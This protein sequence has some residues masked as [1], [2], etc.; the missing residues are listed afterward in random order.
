VNENQA[1]TL[2]ME[3]KNLITMPY[4][5]TLDRQQ[6]EDFNVFARLTTEDVLTLGATWRP[7]LT[8][9]LQTELD[10]VFAKVKICNM[11]FSW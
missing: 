9:E 4:Q 2:Y 11:V 10:N 8:R 5:D 6:R 1:L 7:E 3:L